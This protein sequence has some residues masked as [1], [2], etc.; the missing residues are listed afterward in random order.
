MFTFGKSM[1][2]AN[3]QISY[4][5]VIMVLKLIQYSPSINFLMKIVV[6]TRVSAG[7]FSRRD[8]SKDLANFETRQISLGNQNT[9]FN[10]YY[11]LIECQS[12][13][14]SVAWVFP[15]PPPLLPSAIAVRSFIIVVGSGRSR[16]Q[17]K[18]FDEVW[19]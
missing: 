8:T 16:L 7:D 2:W 6:I 10:Q 17:S 18:V 12:L 1:R 9:I 4:L 19:P 15:L 11:Y 13:P 14:I 5:S 3:H